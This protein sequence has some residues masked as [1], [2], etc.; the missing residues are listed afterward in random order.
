MQLPVCSLHCIR[1]RFLGIRIP[2]RSPAFTSIAFHAYLLLL[3]SGCRKH[4]VIWDLYMLHTIIAPA[5]NTTDGT[6]PSVN[7]IF[8]TSSQCLQLRIKCLIPRLSACSIKYGNMNQ[9]YLGFQNFWDH[10]AK[11][12]AHEKKREEMSGG[13]IFYSSHGLYLQSA[14]FESVHFLV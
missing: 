12:P 5:Q 8:Y 11:I 10:R 7:N 9:R 3:S 4:S 6:G 13:N 14:V 2:S 1:P